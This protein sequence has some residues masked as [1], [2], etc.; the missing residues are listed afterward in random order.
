MQWPYHA[1][2]SIQFDGP[3]IW[4]ISILIDLKEPALWKLVIWNPEAKL[5]YI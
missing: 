3:A 1:D 5:A 4:F 2:S